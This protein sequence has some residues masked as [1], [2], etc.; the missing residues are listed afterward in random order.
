MFVGQSQHTLDEKNRLVLPAK[1]RDILSA[2]DPAKAV[3]V[4][5][6]AKERC[7]FLSIKPV[8][9]WQREIE[10]IERAAEQSEDAEWFMRKHCWDAECCKLDP[11]GRL[12]VPTRLTEAAGLKRDVMIVGSH[13]A[14]EV[15][16][17][18]VWKREDERLRHQ[19]P[20]LQKSI[21]RAHDSRGGEPPRG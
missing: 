9:A 13:R 2:S 10:R 11:Q 7:S 20:L 8:E 19:A 4:T 5:L 12:M 14:I 1:F 16:D 18:D 21:Y 3:Y 17:V 6:Q 15:W